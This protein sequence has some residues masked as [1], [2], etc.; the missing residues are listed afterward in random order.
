[1]TPKQAVFDAVDSPSPAL[2]DKCV[3]CGFC[4]PSCPTYL[5][6]GEE[7]D[8]PRGRIYLM[9]AGLEGRADDDVVVRAALRRVPRV[10][11]VCDGVSVRRAVRS[12]DRAN[13]GADRATPPTGDWPIDCSAARCSASFR[14][15]DVSACCSFPWCFSVVRWRRSAVRRL[16]TCCRLARA[17]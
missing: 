10:H 15:Q 4:L 7:M 9:K 17:R 14:T 1:M 5:L 2:I 11:G 12:A 6:W 3:H 8:S 13:P 16:R